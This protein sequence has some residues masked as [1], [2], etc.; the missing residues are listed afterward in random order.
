MLLDKWYV[1]FALD[2]LAESRAVD[3]CLQ[4]YQQ[5]WHFL[6]SHSPGRSVVH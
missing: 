5:A 1:C 4:F 2:V 3:R 6:H